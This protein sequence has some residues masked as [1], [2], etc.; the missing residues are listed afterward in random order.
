M[1]SFIYISGILGGL[2]LAIRLMGTITNFT[3]NDEFLISGLALIVLIFIP[4]SIVSRYKQN[5]KIDKI[6]ASYKGT[7]KET[8]QFEKGKS[9]TEGWGMNNSPFRERKSGLTWGGGNIKGANASR[10]TRRSF[11]K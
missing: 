4:L 5:K 6:I 3:Y 7:N 1:R 11:L 10:G 9:Q 8:I 2:L